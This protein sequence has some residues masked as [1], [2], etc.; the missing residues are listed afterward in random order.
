VLRRRALARDERAVRAALIALR[1]GGFAEEIRSALGVATASVA[2][3]ER[4]ATQP[5]VGDPAADATEAAATAAETAEAKR[6]SPELP[7]R[8]AAATLH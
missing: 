3:G 5:L 6:V 7:R 8:R 4:P 2:P 1:D